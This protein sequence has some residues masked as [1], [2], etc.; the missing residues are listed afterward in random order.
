MKRRWLHWILPLPVALLGW[1]AW[2]EGRGVRQTDSPWGGELRFALRSDP[3]TL[4]PHLVTEEAAE[5]V[6][7]LTH[8]AL[9]RINRKTQRLEPELAESWK[10]DPSGHTISF[11]LRR[12]VQFSDGAALTGAD[13]VFSLRRVLDPA[14]KSPLAGVFGGPGATVTVQTPAPD[15]L[16]LT[17]PAPIASLDRHFA[18]LSILAANSPRAGLGPFVLAEAKPGISLRFRRNPH[19]WRVENGRRLPYVDAVRIDIQANRDLELARFRRG[20]L[21]LVDNVDPESFDRL[22]RER[23][24]QAIDAGPSTDNEFLWFNQSPQAPLPAH[25]KAWFQ[26]RGFRRAIS[27]SIRRDDLVRLVYLGRATPAA[28]P[29]PPSNQFWFRSGLTPPALNAAAAKR[30]LAEEGF[31]WN[32]EGQLL[33][34][35]GNRVEFSLISNSGSKTRARIAALIQNDLAALGIQLNFV[36]LDFPSLV[37]RISRTAN[38]EACLLGFVNQDWD[39]QSQMNVWRSSAPQHAWNPG[40]KSPATRWEAEIDRLMQQ[41]SAEVDSRK[42]KAAFDRVQQIA[43]EEAPI[44]YLVYRNALM[45]ASPRVRNLQATPWTPHLIWNIEQLAV[46]GSSRP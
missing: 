12:G 1:V 20:E 31:R 43:A 7:L 5:T 38:Y 3:K 27:E 46:E 22:Q 11:Q 8:A 32:G 29:V 30:R 10:T 35:A 26:S 36:P 9:V 6:R 34:R 39:P 33:D 44:V 18:S 19:Y 2:L 37:E 21:D 23:A 45:A 16:V 24:G 42:R 17:F 40:Q 14:T 41:Q 28:G 4:D 13:V 25:K 15:R